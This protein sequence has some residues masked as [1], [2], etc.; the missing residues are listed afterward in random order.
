MRKRF[1]LDTNRFDRIWPKV[2]NSINGMGRFI[3]HYVG[4]KRRIH[5][6]N[7]ELTQLRAAVTNTINNNAS[8][9]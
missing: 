8:K 4:V 3:T 9:E 2:R 7:S 5:D 6:L 1:L